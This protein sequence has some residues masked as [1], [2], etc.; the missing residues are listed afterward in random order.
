MHP[1]STRVQAAQDLRSWMLD[2]I[3]SNYFSN[4]LMELQVRKSVAPHQEI[5]QENN[6]NKVSFLARWVTLLP[7][8]Q[9]R[10]LLLTS[11]S[12]MCTEL[13]LHFFVAHNV[14]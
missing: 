3:E 5:T 10:T 9:S 8:A 14:V 6:F 7:Y 4:N 11:L 2:D 12:V 1:R 13:G